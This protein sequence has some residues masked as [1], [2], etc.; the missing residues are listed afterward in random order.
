MSLF[1]EFFHHVTLEKNLEELFSKE[2][3]HELNLPS[4]THL[5]IYQ[6]LPRGKPPLS[7]QVHPHFSDLRILKKRIADKALLSLY[8]NCPSHYSHSLTL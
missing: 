4:S 1:S 7:F 2:L 5:N 3:F 6:G 8:D